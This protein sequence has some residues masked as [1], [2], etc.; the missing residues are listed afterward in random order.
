MEASPKRRRTDADE[1][2][3]PSAGNGDARWEATI[4]AVKPAIVALR[5]TA[6]RPFEGESAGTYHGT[7][8]VVDSDRGLILTNRHIVTNGPILGMATFDENE[9]VEC[10][11]VYRDPIHDYG[12]LQFEP[13]KLHYTRRAQID[14]RPDE[15]K[16]G[17]EVR[18]LGNDNAEKLHPFWHDRTRGPERPCLRRGLFR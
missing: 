4:A 9:E 1:G 3:W 12:F 13:K 2:A 18:V 7:G 16:V 15:L 14:L 10:F 6:V 8:F 11:P 17:A 5:I